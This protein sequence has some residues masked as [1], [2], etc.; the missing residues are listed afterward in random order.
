MRTD[1]LAGL[2]ARGID[3][4][5]MADYLCTDS[6]K[7]YSKNRPSLQLLRRV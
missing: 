4:L 6:E 1:F 7:Y 5:N 2:D 3:C